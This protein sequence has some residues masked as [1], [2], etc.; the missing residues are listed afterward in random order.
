MTQPKLSYA[1]GCSDVPLLGET[2]GHNLRTTAARH[3]ARDALVDVPSGRR[4][5][6][7]QLDAEVD[8]LAR[9][10]IASGVAKGDRVGLWSPNLPEWV[11]TQYACARIGAIMVNVNPAYG[12]REL[13]YVLEQ[14][15]VS[16]LIAAERWKTTEYRPVIDQVRP[17][18]AALKQVVYIGAR[19]YD[20]LWARASEVT[21]ARLAEREALLDFDDPINIQ[22]TSGTTGFPKGARSHHNLL[23]NGYFCGRAQRLHPSTIACA[24]RCRSITASA[25]S[26]ATWPRPRTAR[27]W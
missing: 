8:Q 25:W 4:W 18:C 17:S 13:A 6:Y 21:P 22:Y 10:L 2:I 12:S 9:A 3:A 19:E 11:I 20:A 14:A 16:L 26:S 7:A 24:C 15:G 5:S 23:N 1:S 27:A